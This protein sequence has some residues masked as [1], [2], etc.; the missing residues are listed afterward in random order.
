MTILIESDLSEEQRIIFMEVITDS[1]RVTYKKDLF[2]WLQ[3]GFQY[4][5]AHDVF[6]YGVCSLESEQFEF[7]YLTTTLHFS[8]Q[9]FQAITQKDTGLI[10]QAFKHWQTNNLPVFVST[11]LP[12]KQHANYNV[13]NI[14]LSDMQP[15]ELNQFVVH[16]FGD[17][18][19][20]ISTMVM[21]GRMN[22]PINELT[23]YLLEL[24]MPH[25]HCALVKVHANR[26]VM[27]SFVNKDAILK[28]ITKREAEVLQWLHMGKTNWEISTILDISPTTVKNHVQNIIRK[29]GVENRGQAATKA[30]RLGLITP[31]QFRE[32]N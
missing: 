24:L 5:I 9:Q 1:L 12:S 28:A 32:Y 8:D 19:T 22:A 2:N 31:N 4:L 10:H 30:V 25:V 11:D 20:R 6:F 21:L 15:T 29:L 17:M 18:R 27:Q 7:E 13:L 14:S 16:G 3:H 26:A 23:A